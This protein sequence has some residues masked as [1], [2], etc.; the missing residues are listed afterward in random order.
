MLKYSLTE[1]KPLLPKNTKKYNVSSMMKLKKQLANEKNLL[2]DEFKKQNFGK[3][4]REFDPFKK[5]KKLVAHLGNTYNISNAWLKCYE[6]LIDLELLPDDTDDFLHFDNAAFPG[7]FMLAT[8]HAIYTKH[9]WKKNYRWVASS[10]INQ[11]ELNADPLEDKYKLY[12]NY[13][14]NWLMTSEYDGDVLNRDVQQH[15]HDELKNQVDLYTSDIGFDVSNDYNN[16]ELI[17]LPVHIGQIISGLLTMK[18]G[19]HFI[20]KQYMFFESNTISI[21]YG[22]SQLFEEFYICKPYTSREANS[23]TYLVGKGFLQ[24]SL[25]LEHPFVSAM[26]E[27]IENKDKFSVPLFDW[28]QYP[29]KFKK[30]IVASA[31]E[32]FTRQIKKISLDIQRVN[33]CIKQRVKDAP[34]KHPVV[35]EFH[36]SIEPDLEKWHTDMNI[37]PIKTSNRLHMFDLYRQKL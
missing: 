4:W 25:T 13:P 20:V 12:Q 6:M 37:S 22:L 32:I 26:F 10:L 3:F 14:D 21:I 8:R 31:K 18:K 23:E 9:S 7:S 16:Q 19:A 2:D 29:S 15:F 17:Q 35:K 11:N 27:R 28:K 5:E 34:W 30:Q 33:K 1:K 24:D 36:T